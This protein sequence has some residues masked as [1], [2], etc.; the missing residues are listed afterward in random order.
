M[1]T[2]GY[3]R[4]LGRVNELIVRGGQ[5]V[6][7]R[8]VESLLLEHPA[9]AEVA[10]VGVQDRFWG[11]T[12]AAIVRLSSPV[13]APAAE[14]TEFCRSHLTADKVPVRWLFVDSLPR[15]PDGKVCK[16]ALGARLA[17]ASEPDWQSWTNETPTALAEVLGANEHDPVNLTGPL[18]ELLG[19]RVPQQTPRSKALE[20]IDF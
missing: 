12:V 6:Y 19:L 14:L 1:D 20:D 17:D 4:V 18:A 2:R 7:P 13:S 5:C 9:V 10:V 16:T 8:E 11:E 3:C 15:T